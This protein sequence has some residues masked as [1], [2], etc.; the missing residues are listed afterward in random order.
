MILYLKAV[1]Y[2]PSQI[3]VYNHVYPR[4]SATDLFIIDYTFCIDYICDF[5]TI[6]IRYLDSFDDRGM[7]ELTCNYG[8]D[9]TVTRGF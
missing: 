5:S 1:R 8:Y 9:N 3:A 7:I 2:L 6:E 4:K